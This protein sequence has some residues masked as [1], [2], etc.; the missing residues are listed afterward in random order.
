MENGAG[1][2]RQWDTSGS[3]SYS[4]HSALGDVSEVVTPEIV[5]T[6]GREEHRHFW[7]GIASAKAPW[8]GANLGFASNSGW[9]LGFP[10]GLFRGIVRAASWDSKGAT[11]AQGDLGCVRRADSVLALGDRNGIR[12]RNGWSRR[13]HGVKQLSHLPVHQA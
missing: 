9:S 8:Q 12:D 5:E 10:K 2:S 6:P 4:S 13:V 11:G 3:C 1:A 7:S